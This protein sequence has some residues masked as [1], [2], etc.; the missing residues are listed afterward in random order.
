MGILRGVDRRNLYLRTGA[1][2]NIL[3]HDQYGGGHSRNPS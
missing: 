2:Q 3:S 1:E